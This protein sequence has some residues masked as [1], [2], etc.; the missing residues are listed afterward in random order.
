MPFV[1]LRCL[2]LDKKHL[3]PELWVVYRV[4]MAMYPF[5]LSIAVEGQRNLVWFC[6]TLKHLVYQFFMA[7]EGNIIRLLNDQQCAEKDA[8]WL[9]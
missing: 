7:L 1:I 8:A 6:L 9:R 5:Q 2:F 4:C 3:I